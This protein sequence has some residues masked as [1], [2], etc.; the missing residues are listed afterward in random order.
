MISITRKLWREAPLI[1]LQKTVWQ[2]LTNIQCWLTLSQQ[3]I[4]RPVDQILVYTQLTWNQ[5]N[6]RQVKNNVSVVDW[7]VGDSWWSVQ[8][9]FPF[10]LPKIAQKIHLTII[11]SNNQR[12]Q[13]ARDHKWRS[14]HFC[15][16]SL[17]C[18]SFT[19]QMVKTRV[20][21]LRVI[22]GPNLCDQIA[23]CAFHSF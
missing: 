11:T 16:N 17:L 4:D 18:I 15:S 12:L 23:F 14:K 21:R 8:Q 1:K 13:S 3:L 6:A 7:E 19:W 9:P 20:I 10:L 22:E 5:E 2:L